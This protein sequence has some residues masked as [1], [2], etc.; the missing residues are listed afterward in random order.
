LDDVWIVGTLLELFP[1]NNA[2]LPPQLLTVGRPC[3]GPQGGIGLELWGQ[4]KTNPSGKL[5][6]TS[7]KQV[8][9]FVIGTAHSFPYS[10]QT[11]TYFN[12]CL[13]I[14]PSHNTRPSPDT[15]T[16]TLRLYPPPYPFVGY[17]PL[18][19]RMKK[20]ALWRTEHRPRTKAS[21]FENRGQFP[22]K[23]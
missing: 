20:G 13:P 9:P 21:E 5:H 2:T 6:A 12:V 19:T 18:K 7:R 22:G 11:A 15:R 1:N 8:T 16:Q 4:S 10:N 23:T 17:V 3:D 14:R